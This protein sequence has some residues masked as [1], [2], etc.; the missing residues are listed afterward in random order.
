MKGQLEVPVL[1]A[2]RIGWINDSES[3]LDKHD[4]GAR[5]IQLFGVPRR[6][7]DHSMVEG[8]GVDILVPHPCRVQVVAGVLL[9]KSWILVRIRR[10]ISDPIPP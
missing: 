2:E 9:F 10:I 3:V 7:N 4:K 8:G 6:A 5:D 1:V